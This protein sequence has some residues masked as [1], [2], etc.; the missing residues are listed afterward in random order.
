MFISQRPSP[1][2]MRTCPCNK[3][4]YHERETVRPCY[5]VTSIAVVITDK[6]QAKTETQKKS[7]L[8]NK[9]NSERVRSELAGEEVKMAVTQPVKETVSAGKAVIG[10]GARLGRWFSS[11]VH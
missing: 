11:L 1:M 8:T 9:V 5:L 6:S 10:L 3:Y 7:K 4:K 2:P